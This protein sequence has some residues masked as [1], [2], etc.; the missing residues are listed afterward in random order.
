MNPVRAA[1]FDRLTT[2]D[3]PLDG[4]VGDRV[5]HQRAPQGAAFPVVVFAKQSGTPEHAFAG[6]LD[7]ELWLVKAVSKGASAAAAEEIDA[8]IDVALHDAPLDI[9]GHTRLYL[10]RESD[11]D[12]PEYDGADTYHH[13]GGHYRLFTEPS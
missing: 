1:L 8:A 6:R 13:V 5:Y 7:R 12:Y 10:R 9:D 11:V 4:L 3:G 2:T